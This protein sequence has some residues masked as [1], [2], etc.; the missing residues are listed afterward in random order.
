MTPGPLRRL[1]EGALGRTSLGGWARPALREVRSLGWRATVSANAAGEGVRRRRT[2][3][4]V[5]LVAGD[6]EGLASQPRVAVLAE[7]S[8]GAAVR[9]WALRMAGALAASGYPC[10]IVAA[11]DLAGRVEAPHELPAGVAVVARGN[12]RLDFGSWAAAIEAF[13]GLAEAEHVLLANDSIIGPLGDEEAVAALLARGEASGPGVFAATRGLVGSDHLQS[14]WLQFNGTFGH[15]AVTA[16]FAD[17]PR[18]RDR[19]D[20]NL[21][22]EHAL[23]ETLRRSGLTLGWAWDA[24]SWGLPPSY[25][26]SLCWRE[27]LDAGFPFVKRKLLGDHPRFRGVREEVRAHVRERYGVELT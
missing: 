9:P 22:Y 15:P 17:L 14:F 18:T 16:F 6:P 19:A 4:P 21:R 25:N 10:I 3:S 7:F 1:G 11:R 27:L 5:T 13:P 26:P 24:S 2:G 12:D 8:R 23:S 20:L